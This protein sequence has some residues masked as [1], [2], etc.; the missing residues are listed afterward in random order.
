MITIYIG[1][2]L[3]K[4]TSTISAITI[5]GLDVRT[6]PSPNTDINGDFS[7][8]VMVP[9]IPEGNYL[10]SVTTDATTATTQ[11]SI[12]S[13]FYQDTGNADIYIS[14]STV[15]PGE[16][17]TIDGSGFSGYQKVWTVT[18]GGLD[19]SPYPEPMT[20]ALGDFYIYVMVPGL[21]EGSYSVQANV[22]DTSADT[23]V[24]IR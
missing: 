1:I 17:I 16:T 10:V 24:Q 12:L 6:R 13:G 22:G 19:V 2:I 20:N 4:L 9:G 7:T 18:V 23:I 5:G 14:P 21:S 11:I 3:N 8:M 15:S